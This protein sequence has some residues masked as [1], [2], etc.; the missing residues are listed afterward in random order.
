MRLLLFSLLL[1]AVADAPAYAQ[2]P[3]GPSSRIPS[4]A[5]SPYAL[6]SPGYLSAQVS[7]D[8]NWIA[9]GSSRYAALL[10]AP[11]VE[12]D[13]RL[14]IG[15]SVTLSE[16]RGSGY[17]FS[18]T[19]DGRVLARV[20]E[21][22]GVDKQAQLVAFSPQT[23][24]SDVIV[25]QSDMPAPPSVRG[26]S[27]AIADP[28]GE[29]LLVDGSNDSV[30]FVQNERLVLAGADGAT[31]LFADPQGRPLLNVVASLTGR[32]AF[33]IVGG[34][35]MSINLDGSGLVSHGKG[36][37]PAWS[38]DGQWLAFV[39]TTDD[40][41]QMLTS[42]IWIDAPAGGQ[43]TLLSETADRLELRPTWGPGGRSLLYHE[44][45]RG[46]IEVLPLTY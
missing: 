28:A 24:S 20:F 34:D 11:L 39:R 36:E 42:D 31:E 40:G 1:L 5:S 44:L 27:I 9:L 2:A 41:H 18:W 10:A 15:Q 19:S 25:R 29:A 16:A 21:G 23:E 33:E 8:G 37:Q 7:P 32:V 46:L 6:T 26:A 30:P 22:E 38:P 17:G 35:L 4:A 13:G 3:N 43:T 12:E 14:R 45:D